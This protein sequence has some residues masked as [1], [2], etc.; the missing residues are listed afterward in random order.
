MLLQAKKIKKPPVQTTE[1]KTLRLLLKKSYKDTKKYHE[2]GNIND[3]ADAETVDSNNDTNISDVSSNKSP[4]IA[5]KKFINK[6]DNLRKKRKSTLDISKLD[7]APNSKNK[8]AASS[9]NRN[10]I[11]QIAAKKKLQ[12]YK[13][14]S[15]KRT[16]FPFNINDVADAEMVDYHNN[17]NISDASSNKIAQIADKKIVKKYKNL[18]RKQPN[19]N[20]VFSEQLSVHRRDKLVRKTKHDVKFVKQVPLHPHPSS[21]VKRRTL[22]N[23]RNLNKN[24]EDDDVTFIK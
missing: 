18:A 19:N 12:R 24:S 2:K 23:Y 13:K 17:T 4:Q 21:K 14:I 9:N 5:D 8:K 1:I 22:E 11:A 7:V 3:V 15:R 6:Y 20:V 10:K 16:R